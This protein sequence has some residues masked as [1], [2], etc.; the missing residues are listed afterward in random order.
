[1]DQ[2]LIDT[3]VKLIQY[4]DLM[5]ITA[6]R[7]DLYNEKTILLFASRFKS[8]RLLN[9]IY[10][11]TYADMNGVGVGIYTHFNAKLLRTLYRESIASLQ[12]D[13]ILST[14]TR[15]L[16]KMES[17]KKDIRFKSFS[18]SMQRQILSIPA[19]ELFIYNS[20]RQILSIIDMAL[21]VDDF[22]HRI[23]NTEFLT[24]EIVRKKAFSLG[25]LLSRLSRLNIVNL[26]I[27]KLFGGLKY[28]KIDFHEVI[29]ESEL[30]LLEQIIFDSFEPHA[31]T[32]LI[33]PEIKPNEIEIDC[34]HSREYGV[35]RLRTKDQRGL[36]AFVMQLFDQLGIDIVSSKIHTS[37]YRANDLF[38]IEKDG[39]FCHNTDE[40]IEKLTESSC[41]E[42]SDI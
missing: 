21:A 20:T 41:V 6:Q 25:Y 2:A 3:G 23:T 40:I 30:P 31:K 35:L 42:L 9:M 19:N 22:Q 17:L 12:H 28:F 11:L 32:T 37:K 8:E 1:M 15:R 33:K 4:H 26:G 5:S 18:K 36:L 16:K 29:D 27:A 7:E 38:L 39:N 14:T 24:I 10:L 34:E 13:K